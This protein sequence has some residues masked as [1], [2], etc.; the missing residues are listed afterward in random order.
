MHPRWRK[1]LRDECAQTEGL[2]ALAEDRI[3][4][5]T[6]SDGRSCAFMDAIALSSTQLRFHATVMCKNGL[7]TF[8]ILKTIFLFTSRD[9]NSSTIR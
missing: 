8:L 3:D 5:F 7:S 9:D 1:D 6:P 4:A 2:F